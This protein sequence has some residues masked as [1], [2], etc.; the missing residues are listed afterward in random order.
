MQWFNIFKDYYKI[1]D[2]I[3][4]AVYYTPMIYLFYNW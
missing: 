4:C 2:Y 1:T 3:A